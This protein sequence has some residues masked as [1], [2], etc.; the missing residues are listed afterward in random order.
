VPKSETVTRAPAKVSTTAF[1]TTSIT[2]EWEDRSA[3]EAGFF[4]ERSMDGKNWILVGVVA[5]DEES[6]EDQGL[7][8]RTVYYY[9][10]CAFNTNDTDAESAAGPS[11]VARGKTTTP[12]KIAA[13]NAAQTVRR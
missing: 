12:K 10:V 7:V 11:G 5:T 1:S 3:N 4:V 2:L 8:P 9:R 6:F 13:P